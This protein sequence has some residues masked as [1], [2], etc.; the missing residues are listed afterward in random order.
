MAWIKILTGAITAAATTFGLARGVAKKRVESSVAKIIE[1]ASAIARERVRAGASTYLSDAWRSFLTTTVIKAA[2]LSGLFVMSIYN[3]A[4]P[5]SLAL[6]ASVFLILSIIY[7]L[8]TR[9]DLLRD[10]FRW[11][12]RYGLKPRKIIRLTVAQQVFE[13]VLLEYKSQKASLVRKALIHL[14]GHTP[15]ALG[16][17]VAAAVSQTASM[18]AWEDMKPFVRTASIRISLLLAAYSIYATYIIWQLSK[19]S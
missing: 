17:Q 18:A 12:K 2:L 10:L 9:R 13:E 7:D 19:L 3:V 11:V 14:G 1:E 16:A 6:A 4:G 15:D 5:K 8:Y